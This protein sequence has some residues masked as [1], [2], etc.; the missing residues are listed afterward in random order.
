MITD[1]ENLMSA[2]ALGLCER[3][4]SG[5]KR[6]GY[7][8]WCE[9]N[10]IIHRK[11]N[12]DYAGPYSS[13]L[14]PSISRLLQTF[15]EEDDG[16]AWDECGVA[17][18]SQ[19]ALSLHALMAMARR[20]DY[21]PTNMVYAIY[22][23]LEAS[24]IA[25]RFRWIVEGAPN[26]SAS[27]EREGVSEDDMAGRTIR[28]PG[29]TVWFT[30]VGTAGK[31][32]SKPGVG[33]A[34][35]DEVDKV[36]LPKGEASVVDLLRQRGKV[37][38]ARKYLY[39]SSPTLD[40]GPIWKEVLTG[41]GH[42]DF[43][44]CPHCGHFQ[45]LRMDGIKYH[46][47]RDKFG[48]LDLDK[49]RRLAHYEC[50]SCGGTIEEHKHKLDMLQDGEWRPTHFEKK[51][52][53]ETGEIEMVPA[54]VPRKMSAYHSDL[55]ALWEGSRWGDLAVEKIAASKNPEKLQNVV[56][57]RWGEAFKMGAMR[58]VELSHVLAL[59]NKEYGRGESPFEPVMITGQFDTQDSCWK[60]VISA[61]DGD[62]NQAVVDYGIFISWKDVVAFAKKGATWKEKQYSARFC[63][64]DEGGTRTR[65]V[66]RRCLPMT[67]IFNPSK[68]VGG[69]NVR[70]TLEWKDYEVD[71][72]GTEKVNVLTYDDDGFRRLLYRVQILDAG[73]DS[74]APTLQLPKDADE[75]FCQELCHEFLVK[76]QGRWR[77]DTDGPNDFGDAVKMGNI[78]W[79]AC[80]HLI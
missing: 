4:W 23:D 65:E 41:S 51:T 36:K 50:A 54:W 43:V 45:A 25:D 77:Y 15:L 8:E 49:V 62:G 31:T 10:V 1:L 24:N 33:L 26:L 17:K 38:T 61:W 12:A 16:R 55:Y 64:V 59:K 7:R 39:F 56:N 19:S 58:R 79:A 28:L 47:L 66:R 13:R 60:G 11:E 40:S 53:P 6:L 78:A 69:V 76:K 21:Q 67:P 57:G 14:T 71:K 22:S 48:D 5:R 9:G 2:E 32:S 30:G 46:H 34:I 35:F 68:G 42:R 37:T 52:D 63:L 20:A 18:S 72:G 75:S 80:G 73:K 70:R 29:C 27:L 44:P 74:D 3:V